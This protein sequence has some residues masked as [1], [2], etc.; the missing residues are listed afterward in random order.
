[1]KD[2]L[3]QGNVDQ[4]KE[5][6]KYQKLEEQKGRIITRQEAAIEWI[7]LYASSWRKNKQG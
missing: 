7:N 1:M 6:V 4:I 5:I 2:Q 3:R